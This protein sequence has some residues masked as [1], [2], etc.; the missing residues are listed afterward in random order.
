MM[1]AKTERL[2]PEI[3]TKFLD[4]KISEAADGVRY[5]YKAVGEALEVI[6]RSLAHNCGGDLSFFQKVC[7]SCECVIFSHLM[8]LMV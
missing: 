3:D 6:P 5:A 8:V 2:S 7:M 1:L 4:K